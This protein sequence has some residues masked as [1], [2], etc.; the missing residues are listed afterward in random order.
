M[1]HQEYVAELGMLGLQSTRVDASQRDGKHVNVV[2]DLQLWVGVVQWH[3][4]RNTFVQT[5]FERVQQGFNFRI[6]QKS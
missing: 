3:A 5:R 2:V 4:L 6:L 1:N